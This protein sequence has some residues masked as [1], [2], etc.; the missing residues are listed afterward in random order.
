MCRQYLTQYWC[1]CELD[2]GY[3]TCSSSMQNSGCPQLAYETVHMQCFCNSHATK[4]FKTEKQHQKKSRSSLSSTDSG[5]SASSR[6]SRY[7]DAS[8]DQEKSPQQGPVLRRRWYRPW[9]RSF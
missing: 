4:K 6:N 1:Q 2:A 5:S 3:Q 8:L 7:S 9:S